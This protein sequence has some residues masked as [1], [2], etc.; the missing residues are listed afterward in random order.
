MRR[1]TSIVAAALALASVGCGS[2]T[3]TAQDAGTAG[4]DG[5]AAGTGGGAGT[6]GKA[7]TGGGAGNTGGAGT[8]GL[9]GTSGAAGAPGSSIKKLVTG[10]SALV[11]SG[12]DTCTNLPGAKDDRW[13]GFLKAGATN[14][15]ELWVVNAT[16]LASGAPLACD[17]TSPG[18]LRLSATAF[19]DDNFG[20]Q[21]HHFYGDTLIFYA[22]APANA[23]SFTG[24]VWAWRPGWPAAR[25]L[26]STIGND[27]T[28]SKRG[29]AIA[30]IQ[31]AGQIVA[32]ELSVELLAGK[33]PAA[34]DTPLPSIERMVIA[35]MND[36]P[37]VQKWQLAFSEDGAYVA[38]TARD[39]AASPETL[40]IQKLDD[41]AS[42]KTI[43]SDVSRFQLTPDGK[44]F[45]WL[46]AFNYDAAA[47]SGTLETAPFPAG[48]PTTALAAGTAMYQ[49]FPDGSIMFQT[50][51]GAELRR[52]P[53]PATPAATQLLDSAIA[54]VL[55][56]SADGTTIVYA[57]TISPD[58]LIDM[59]A[60]NV[61]AQAPCMVAGPGQ[62]V[63]TATMFAKG[64]IVL[65]PRLDPL[66]G[67]LQG[68][69]TSV[70]GCK[71]TPFANNVLRWIAAGD[72]A[73]TILDETSQVADDSSLRYSRLVNGALPAQGTLLQTHVAGVYG[74]ALPNVPVI[75]YNGA[76]Q[77]TNGLFA[78][79]GPP[80]VGTTPPAGDA[81][82]TE[83]G[84]E[85]GATDGGTDA[86]DAALEAAPDAAAA[87]APQADAAQGG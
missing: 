69:S 64:S 31:G 49:G 20:A 23:A 28:A 30:C 17:G 86:A 87:D 77:A 41:A 76:T 53:N 19:F 80:L 75:L 6:G 3:G 22:D 35:A 52:M 51:T 73:L 46:R 62:A 13:C 7:G 65:W 9:A 16:A 55:D 67:D 29:D 38:W 48:T 39:K 1:L 32:G 21:I 82:A 42:R 72:D 12:E 10:T 57:K 5:A 66:A 11:G 26:T 50:A 85:A 60:R 18:C 34:A 45:L 2:S 70:A 44:S 79:I 25:K 63:P 43:A 74:P 14:N 8:G 59:F 78:Y 68:M 15:I 40:K 54:G 83:G 27:C 81:G 36:A 58:G 71:T 56:F 47:P 61:T 33:P 24:I 37:D 4:R 84:T